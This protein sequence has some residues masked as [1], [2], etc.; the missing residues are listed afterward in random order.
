MDMSP[1]HLE[2]ETL[3]RLVDAGPDALTPAELDHLAGCAACFQ[4][5]AAVVRTLHAS[6]TVRRPGS[7]QSTLATPQ[8]RPQPQVQPQAQPQAPRSPRANVGPPKPGSPPRL[9]PALL[10]PTLTLPLGGAAIAAALVALLFLPPRAATPSS[11]YRGSERSRFLQPVEGEVVG[12]RAVRLRWQAIP[13]ASGYDLRL[14]DESGRTLWEET[15]ASTATHLPASGDLPPGRYRVALDPR[16]ADLA[17][18]GAL[19][20]AFQAG[21]WSQRVAH[22]LRWA[23]PAAGWSALAGLVL[24]LLGLG[25]QLRPGSRRGGTG[26]PILESD[27]GRCQRCT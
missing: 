2:W 1:T 4:E 25:P 13:G 5:Y 20:V 22:R 16:P 14:L 21:S 26:G 23:P 10:R 7:T 17:D 24:L 9:I 19:S 3:A 11:A 8:P 18:P 6:S 12:T 15:T 27:D